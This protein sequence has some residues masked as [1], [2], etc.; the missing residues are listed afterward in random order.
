M[1]MRL[2]ALPTLGAFFLCTAS[3]QTGLE[4]RYDDALP[5][6]PGVRG[7]QS[8]TDF[9]SRHGVSASTTGWAV[10]NIRTLGMTETNRIATIYQ[11]QD[12]STQEMVE[13]A[14]FAESTTTPGTPDE[15]NVLATTGPYLSGAPS[16]TGVAAYYANVSFPAILLPNAP[17]VIAGPDVYVGF[18][19][20][21][22]P[23]WVNDGISVHGSFTD[24]SATPRTTGVEWPSGN[25]A[26]AY[27]PALGA[28]S[29]IGGLNFVQGSGGGA[30][31]V[32]PSTWRVVCNSTCD[33]IADSGTNSVGGVEYG[34]RVGAEES[35]QSAGAYVAA[36]AIGPEN[37]GLAGRYPDPV[38]KTGSSISRE[39]NLKIRTDNNLFTTCLEQV[40][41]SEGTLRGL[42]L[43]PIDAGA[44][45]SLLPG[46]GRFELNPN[47]AL[48]NFS[49]GLFPA[50]T[51]TG[52]VTATYTLDLGGAVGTG[53]FRDAWQSPQPFPVGATFEVFYQALRID[54]GTGQLEFSNCRG[55][56]F[57]G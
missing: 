36:N 53:G 10:Q 33:M 48:F 11:D 39:D 27:P 32:L 57:Q 34:L 4:I 45:G 49:F 14:L 52:A 22:Q 25:I 5:Q 9:T 7:N 26:A 31:T 23:L 56:F 12:A 15:T 24:P 50:Q 19:I 2:L 40:L 3:A 55:H 44:V 8:G 1:K 20:P 35:T 17:T 41:L 21:A 42:G 43:P 18:L 6:L 28:P 29:Y 37:Y 16:S 47:G 46:K 38:N 51:L 30:A 13:L 54:L